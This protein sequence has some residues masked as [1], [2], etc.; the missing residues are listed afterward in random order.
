MT[1]IVPPPAGPAKEGRTTICGEGSYTPAVAGARWRSSPAPP[2]RRLPRRNRPNHR[3]W[4]TRGPH[5]VNPTSSSG[6]P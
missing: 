5:E 4:W 6:H 3:A 1:V 2:G